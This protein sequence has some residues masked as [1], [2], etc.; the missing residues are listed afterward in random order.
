MRPPRRRREG[1]RT[2]GGRGLEEDQSRPEKTRAVREH[3]GTQLANGTL[4][5]SPIA[6]HVGTCDRGSA[7]IFVSPIRSTVYSRVYFTF[8]DHFDFHRVS[9]DLSHLADWSSA[10]EMSS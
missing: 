6:A 5:R 1:Q 4:P 8:H 7:L 2:Q 3:S 10:G 9:V